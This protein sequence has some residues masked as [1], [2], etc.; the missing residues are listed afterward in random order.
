MKI[1]SIGYVRVESSFKNKKHPYRV[2]VEFARPRTRVYVIRKGDEI[3]LQSLFAR[4][5]I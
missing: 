2:R 3:H 4:D 1:K 5:I